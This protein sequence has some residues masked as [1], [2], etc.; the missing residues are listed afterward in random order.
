MTKDQIEKYATEFRGIIRLKYPDLTETD[1]AAIMGYYA[2]FFLNAGQDHQVFKLF[3]GLCY[4]ILTYSDK[5]QTGDISTDSGA[6]SSDQAFGQQS[7][8][9]TSSDSR[10]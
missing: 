8:P 5:E 10:D 7:E 6:T 1:T 4:D 3:G 2:A 9:S